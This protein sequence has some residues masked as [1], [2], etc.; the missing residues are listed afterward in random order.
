MIAGT[1]VPHI[2]SYLGIR[3]VAYETMT[4]YNDDEV[5]IEVLDHSYPGE[6]DDKKIIVMTKTI[7]PASTTWML[8]DEK[9]RKVLVK[10]R[11]VYQSM[12]VIPGATDR[13]WDKI[14]YNFKRRNMSIDVRMN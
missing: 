10:D 6:Y 9:E 8:V 5:I 7:P 2:R 13:D 12:V 11:L 1:D 4:E 14:R 3:K